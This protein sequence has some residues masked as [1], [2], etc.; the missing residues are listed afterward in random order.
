MKTTPYELVFG[1]PPQSTLFPGVSGRVM[2][3]DVEELLVKGCVCLHAYMFT[4]VLFHTVILVNSLGAENDGLQ[5]DWSPTQKQGPLEG[6]HPNAPSNTLPQQSLKKSLHL[7]APQSTAPEEGL[8]P[9]KDVEA[10]TS[11]SAVLK[12]DAAESQCQ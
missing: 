5:P 12:H 4:L 6:L 8:S 2:E 11:T 10:G 1:Q 9:V 3:K 7:N